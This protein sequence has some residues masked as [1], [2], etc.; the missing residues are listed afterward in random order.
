M[1]TTN[2]IDGRTPVPAS[3]L[4]DVD[5]V[6]YDDDGANYI[7]YTPV[8]AGSVATTVQAKL[9]E[10]VS[11]NDFGAVGD[12][13]T[14]DRPAFVLAEATGISP[15]LVTKDHY[16]STNTSSTSSVYELNGDAS[17]TTGVGVFGP[18][19]YIQNGSKTFDR[20]VNVTATNPNPIPE[21]Y[22]NLDTG[23]QYEWYWINQWGYQEPDTE[24][25]L[26]GP[27]KGPFPLGQTRL[28]RTGSTQFNLRASHS[29]MGD[30]YNIVA[31]MAVTP[32]TTDDPITYWSGQNS[33]G[34][35][36]CQVNALGD[37]VNLYGAGDLV[38]NDKGFNDIGMLGFVSILYC[39]GADSGA[40]KVPRFNYLASSSGSN[41]LDHAYGAQGKYFVG[42]DLSGGDY[43]SDFG[44]TLAADQRIGFDA[45]TASA[46]KFTTQSGG[47]YWI[48]KPSTLPLVRIVANNNPTLQVRVDR[49]EVSPDSETAY[50]LRVRGSSAT[51]SMAVGQIGENSYV[52]ALTTGAESTVL[53]LQAANSSGAEGVVLKLV[54]ARGAVN[55]PNISTYATNAAAITGGLVAGDVYKTA[56]GE[57]RIV[58]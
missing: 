58:V 17:I 25:N 55:I 30:G 52:S 23:Y 57:L 56:T 41:D 22:T 53:N 4:N 18:N 28:A 19:R 48:D 54:G 35:L 26:S 9:R 7:N 24:G 13:V 33:G 8:G 27:S 42:L 46:G 15:I 39:S 5:R 45:G 11:V 14:D 1:A 51:A 34:F 31:S 37:K 43:S 21:V 36:G 29:G 32:Q 47:L 10:S 50:S 2:F 3:W 12:G 6:I 20:K 38:L 44:I 49:V 40:Y 16:L